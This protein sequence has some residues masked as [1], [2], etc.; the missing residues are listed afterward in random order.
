M[1]NDK[2]TGLDIGKEEITHDICGGCVEGPADMPLLEFVGV[3]AINDVQIVKAS[4]IL[5]M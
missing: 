5:P 4:I 1:E 3:S 2:S